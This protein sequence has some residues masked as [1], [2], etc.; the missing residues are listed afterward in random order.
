MSLRMP[1]PGKPHDPAAF[2][3]LRLFPASKP[4]FLIHFNRTDIGGIDEK[5]AGKVCRS[6]KDGVQC[7][8]QQSCSNS[9]TLTI[10][11]NA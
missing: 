5:P 2:L 3:R 4:P 9:A 10:R 1:S 11:R 7:F 6:L 8:F